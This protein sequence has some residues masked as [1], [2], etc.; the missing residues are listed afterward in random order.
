MRFQACLIPKKYSEIE[1]AALNLH[2]ETN[3]TD[4]Q[5]G[6]RHPLERSD[7]GGG[8]APLGYMAQ[9]TGGR[10]TVPPGHSTP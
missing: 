5:E 6:A 1:K 3:P 8:E 10:R 4:T 2:A 9:G 7:K